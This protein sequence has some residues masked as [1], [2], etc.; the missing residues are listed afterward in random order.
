MRAQV[1]LPSSCPFARQGFG[2]AKI[3]RGGEEGV[4]AIQS[5]RPDGVFY[6]VCVYLDA[7][8]GQEYLQPVPVAVDI[9]EL[10]AMAVFGGGREDQETIRG[11]VFPNDAALMGQPLV[12]S[13][14]STVR[15]AL[16]E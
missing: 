2:R 11:I 1:M 5:D 14:R 9:A 12:A 7:A 15:I 10:F 8:I 6:Q 16:G 3:P 13:R 4:L